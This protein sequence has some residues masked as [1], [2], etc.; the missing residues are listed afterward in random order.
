MNSISNDELNDLRPLTSPEIAEV[1]DR[2]NEEQDI[3]LDEGSPRPF[4]R[5]SS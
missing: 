4:R 3:E 1:K 2:D 5:P